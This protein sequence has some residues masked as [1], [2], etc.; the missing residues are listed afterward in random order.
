MSKKEKS[1]KKQGEGQKKDMRGMASTSTSPPS[2]WDRVGVKGCCP[3]AGTGTSHYTGVQAAVRS[4]QRA[5]GAQEGGSKPVE[6]I[7]SA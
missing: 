1:D 2:W 3:L 6:F 5:D 4:I 7:L